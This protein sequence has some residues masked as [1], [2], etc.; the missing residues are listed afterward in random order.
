VRAPPVAVESRVAV[1]DGDVVAEE[2]RPLGA[3]VGDQG[4]ALV[5]FQAEGLSQERGQLLVP[6]Q[7]SLIAAEQQFFVVYAALRYSLIRPPRT[8]VRSILALMS[9]A[10]PGWRLGGSC[11]RPWCGRWPL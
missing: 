6:C 10:R 7:N 4:L 3:G 5:Q 2:P 11:R 8:C 1:L 9:R